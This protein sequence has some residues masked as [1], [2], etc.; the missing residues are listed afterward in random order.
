MERRRKERM[1]AIAIAEREGERKGR[2]RN[3]DLS[4]PPS[5]FGCLHQ[6]QQRNFLLFSCST[7]NARMDRGGAE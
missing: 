4:L 7:M 1:D 6:P 2:R 3:Q 5:A